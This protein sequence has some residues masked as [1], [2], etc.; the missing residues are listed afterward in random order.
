[1]KMKM[2]GLALPAAAN[3]A[4]EGGGLSAGAMVSI[5]A[6]VIEW[7]PTQDRYRVQFLHNG[8]RGLLRSSNLMQ[9]EFGD[10]LLA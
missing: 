6:T 10:L 2:K 5:S 1:M 8:S 3:W 9:S 4:A 7:L